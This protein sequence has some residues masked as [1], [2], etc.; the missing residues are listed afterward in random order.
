MQPQILHNAVLTA[1]FPWKGWAYSAHE[2]YVDIP[3]PGYNNS[4]LHLKQNITWKVQLAH[5]ESPNALEKTPD[6]WWHDCRCEGA[7]A[8][9]ATA[10][11]AHF[12]LYPSSWGK[13]HKQEQI[14]WPRHLLELMRSNTL[15]PRGQACLFCSA[16]LY[17]VTV[18]CSLLCSSA[19]TWPHTEQISL[20]SLAEMK[21]KVLS[22]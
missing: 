3:C 7:A 22:D 8:A 13:Q 2:G 20:I 1:G 19:I 9:Q 16:F 5:P 12:T 10:T 14:L 17:L 15:Q 21:K 6:Q 11:K 18:P 4:N